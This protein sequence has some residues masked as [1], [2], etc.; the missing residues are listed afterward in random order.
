[1]SLCV[2]TTFF[3]NANSCHGLLESLGLNFDCAANAYGL[4]F[5]EFDS[6]DDPLLCNALQSTQNTVV[7]ASPV[8]PY[9][10]E[11]CAGISDNY[12]VTPP[13]DPSFAPLLPPF[14]AQSL[15]EVTVAAILDNL[16][17]FLESQCLEAAY[18]LYC[19]TL[20][21][22][23]FKSH[24]LDPYFGPTYFPSFPAKSLC[25]AFND[26][27]KFLATIVPT[28]KLNC[29]QLVPGTT[30]ELFPETNQVNSPFI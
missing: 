6:S 10:G 24:A 1:M 9:I 7:V 15:A 16:P 3:G 5:S 28:S 12:Y 2:A 23:P 18:K 27:C 8:E 20:V 29:E 17:R 30:L 11:T 14:V 4:P 13:S 22:K 25:E 26:E 21:M 19:A